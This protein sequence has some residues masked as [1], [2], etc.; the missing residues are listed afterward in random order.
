M[1]CWVTDDGQCG[2]LGSNRFNGGT[3]FRVEASC[4]Y[5]VTDKYHRIPLL[6]PL[7]VFL[8]FYRSLSWPAAPANEMVEERERDA[9]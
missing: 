8:P 5:D 3:D 1:G 4:N 2:N 9:Q 6:D 7:S